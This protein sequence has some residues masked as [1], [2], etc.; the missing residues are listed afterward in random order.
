MSNGTLPADT[1]RN[2]ILLQVARLYLPVGLMGLFIGGVLATA[3]STIDSYLLI[4]SGNVVYDM[5]RPLTR[6]PLSDRTLVRLTRIS[7]VLSAIV[8]IFI[9]L[10]FER[11]KE[12]WAFM[13]SILTATVMVPFLAA[14]LVRGP[15]IRLAGTLSTTGGLVALI[16]FYILM[17]ILGQENADLET[18]EVQVAGFTVLREYGLFFALPFSVAGYAAGD[19]FG[20]RP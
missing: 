9:G 3:M 7:I 14:L 18:R 5:V 19:L 20:R 12:A 10:Y 8:C 4:A 1:P 17:E 15:K 16:L 6:R 13:A 11:I 2:E